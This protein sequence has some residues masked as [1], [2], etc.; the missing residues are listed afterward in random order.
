MKYKTYLENK[1]FSQSSIKT[2][3][4]VSNRFILWLK[5]QRLNLSEI[6]YNDITTYINY[7][8][9]KRNK[10]R[11]I[12]QEIGALKHYLNYQKL[13]GNITHLPINH[14]KIQGVKR[15]SIHEILSPEELDYI[16]QSYPSEN[17]QEKTLTAIELRN[18]IVI[19]LMVYQGLNVTDMSRIRLEHLQLHRGTIDI[20]ATKKS[21]GRTLRLKPHQA[22]DL[23]QFILVE[24]EQLIKQAQK[25]VTEELIFSLGVGNGIS[26]L[27]FKLMKTLKAQHP[28][29]KS[30]KQIRASVITNW[31]KEYNLREVQYRAGH[32]FVSSTESYKIH[33]IESLKNDIV[34][35]S[36]N[37]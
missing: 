7:L 16:Y 23:H 17:L 13:I 27:L 4:V 30:A 12:Q 33:D 37:L 8:Q 36:P 11:T 9:N 10:Q 26:N 15:Q 22:I 19:G 28:E 5:N 14:L 32:R 6:T 34:Q 35:F 1:N 2:Y 31:L 25:P 18:K 21:N 3:Q 20:Q 24:R 29:I